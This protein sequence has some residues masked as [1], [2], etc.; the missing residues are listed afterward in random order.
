MYAPLTSVLSTGPCVRIKLGTVLGALTDDEPAMCEYTSPL[1]FQTPRSPIVAP[2][3]D[4]AGVEV[5]GRPVDT[6]GTGSACAV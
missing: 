1:S 5:A 3:A 4:L 6:D 2:F